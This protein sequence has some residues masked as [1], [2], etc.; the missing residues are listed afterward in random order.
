MN[1]DSGPLKFVCYKQTAENGQW[2]DFTWTPP[3]GVFDDGFDVEPIVIKSRAVDNATD[4]D[5][6][7]S[8]TYIVRSVNATAPDGSA[9]HAGQAIGIVSDQTTD[10]PDLEIPYDASCAP[11][12]PYLQFPGPDNI[13]EKNGKYYLTGGTV[14]FQDSSRYI[15]KGTVSSQPNM[16]PMAYHAQYKANIGLEFDD[17]DGNPYNAYGDEYPEYG[18]KFPLAMYIKYGATTISPSMIL[19]TSESFLD[20]YVRSAWGEP[21]SAFQVYGFLVPTAAGYKFVKTVNGLADAVKTNTGFMFHPV[22]VYRNYQANKDQRTSK[23]RT[24]NLHE[25]AGQTQTVKQVVTFQPFDAVDG[26]TGTF[27]D[28]PVWKV[29]TGADPEDA[30]SWSDLTA[31]N[32]SWAAYSVPEIAGYVASQT[33]L[34]AQA[35]DKDTADQTIDIY[36]KEQ[37]QTNSESKTLTRT[38]TVVRPDGQ[39]DVTVQTVNFSRTVKTSAVT[40][41]KT[42]GAWTPASGTFSAFTAPEIMGYDPSVAQVAEQTVSAADIAS[43]QD[44]QIKITYTEQR[45]A[46]DEPII[47][48]VPTNPTNPTNPN[49][50]NGQP[51]KPNNSGEHGQTNHGEHNQDHGNQSDNQGHKENNQSH[52]GNKSSN[53]K[54]SSQGQPS[55]SPAQNNVPR[56][57]TGKVSRLSNV[58]R[59][60]LLQEGGAVQLDRQSAYKLADVQTNGTQQ[61]GRAKADSYRHGGRD[62]K[63][64]ARK[65]ENAKKAKEAEKDKNSKFKNQPVSKQSL[66]RMYGEH[67]Q[68][69]IAIFLSALLGFFA[70]LFRRRDERW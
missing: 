27:L 39:Q 70:V 42:Y 17:L 43:W 59:N 48:H 61:Q 28:E 29:L 60:Q 68:S 16:S 7:V 10:I 36:Y 38:I 24:I 2:S 56:R 15:Y 45:F 65:H 5:R 37:T 35:V 8:A 1:G 55:H 20:A 31:D 63:L 46:P 51:D 44:P 11:Y 58:S 30:D 54:H 23:T 21:D 19:Q 69:G 26:I 64:H 53:G 13:V 47:P 9:K 67:E 32:H 12:Y 34:P 6:N 40:G 18:A 4:N 22:V 33:A 66:V 62:L 25:P 52:N 50:P 49:K 14:T 41:K 3:E 57:N